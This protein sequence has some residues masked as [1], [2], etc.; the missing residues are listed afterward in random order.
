MQQRNFNTNNPIVANCSAYGKT[1]S[2]T[3]S[4]FS[5]NEVEI[6]HY[7]ITPRI[8]KIKSISSCNNHVTNSS[9]NDKKKW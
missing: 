4:P 2:P 5:M 6:S 9:I 3:M 8:L 7:E 1:M